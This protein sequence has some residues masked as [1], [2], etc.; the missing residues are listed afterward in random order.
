MS[1]HQPSKY[2]Q[3]V[4]D[5]IEYGEGNAVVNAVAGSGKSTTIVNALKLIP[6]DK[7]ILFLAF[8]KSIVEE[9]KIKVAFQPNVEVLTLHSMGCKA[10][11]NQ[12]SCRIDADKYKTHL[13]EGLKFGKYKPVSD[14]EFEQVGEY[15]Q[16]ILRLIDLVRVNMCRSVEM[17]P[18]LAD[19]HDL[20]ILDNECEI[21]AQVCRWG[22]KQ[23]D[24]ID[25]TDMVYFPAIKDIKVKKYDWVFV[26]ECQG[27]KRSAKGIIY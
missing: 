25:F 18:E 10:L 15:K 16:N 20:D 1:K 4:Y 12:I 11:M 17:F 13:Y 26:D 3:V 21:A 8:N 19:S 27:P 5:F 6:E 24:T 22:F 2:Q 9:L 23:L 14:L 7:S